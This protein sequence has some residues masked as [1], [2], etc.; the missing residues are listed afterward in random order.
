MMYRSRLR[1]AAKEKPNFAGHYILTAW[2]A[3][4]NA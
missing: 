1:E 3:E 2:D 4:H